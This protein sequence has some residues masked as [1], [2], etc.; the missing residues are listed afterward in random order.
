MAGQMIREAQ[1][2]HES[3]LVLTPVEKPWPEQALC[4][5]ALNIFE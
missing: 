2:L 5:G 3:D 4:A 1:L